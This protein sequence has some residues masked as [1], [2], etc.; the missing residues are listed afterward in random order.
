[1]SI[2]S[3]LAVH[4]FRNHHHWV[5]DRPDDAPLLVCLTG[6]NGAGKTNI[7]EAISV[8]VP[9]RGLRGARAID[10][11]RHNQPVPWVVAAMVN[12][13]KIG[14]GLAPPD[15]KIGL[16]SEKRQIRLNDQNAT[17]QQLG[18]LLKIIWLTP[19]HDRLFADS[20]SDRRRFLDRLV[21]SL[22]PDHGRHCSQYEKNLRE[23]SRIL[24]DHPRDGVWLAAVEKNL[25]ETG[26]AI[27]AA[28]LR[29]VNALNQLV[30]EQDIFPS[31]HLAL[32]GT[33]EEKCLETPDNQ[34]NIYWMRQQLAANRPID[35]QTG[36]NRLGPHRS[37][38][39][40]RHLPRDIDAADGSTGEQ[41]AVL[42]AVMLNHARLMRVMTG[43]APMLL[44]DEVTAHL[45]EKRRRG[46]WPLLAGLGSQ[47][48]MT[49][50]EP[51]LFA[52]LG[53][54]ACFYSLP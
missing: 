10:C 43:A 8:L 38:W 27:T 6:P 49:G 50:T 12:D 35:Q 54:T 4:D 45:D 44:L 52:E 28:R 23:R 13:Q 51:G 14:V 26:V 34:Q 19:L 3:H 1:M 11:C 17:M 53:D 42:L 37:D 22:A 24:R 41:K 33:I 2:L 20:G 39:R 9:G 5:F 46:L 25:A 16:L 32:G 31:V 21:F 40:A 7:L 18:E 48:W 47:V 29:L 36:T 15:A 30:P